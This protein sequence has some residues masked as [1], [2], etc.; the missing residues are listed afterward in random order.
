[1]RRGEGNSG[2]GGEGWWCITILPS[3]CFPTM[4]GELWNSWLP[5]RTSYGSSNTLVSLGQA[6]GHEGGEG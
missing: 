3:A 4:N 5:L 2:G 1:M 6:A